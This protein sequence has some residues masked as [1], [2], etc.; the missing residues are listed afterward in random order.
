LYSQCGSA[1]VLKRKKD[2]DEQNKEVV[3]LKKNKKAVGL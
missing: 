1:H 2:N 3:E